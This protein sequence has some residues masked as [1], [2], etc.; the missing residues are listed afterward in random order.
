MGFIGFLGGGLVT[1]SLNTRG[2]VIPSQFPHNQLPSDPMAEINRAIRSI[3]LADYVPLLLAAFAVIFVL[4]IIFLYISCRFRFILFDSIITGQPVIGRGWARYSSQ[5]N[6]YFGFW[7]VFRLVSW[8]VMFFIVGLPLWRAYKSGTFSG[9]NSML[10]FLQIIGSIALG[11]L[12]AAIVFGIISTLVKDFVM[13]IM[14]LDDFSLGDAWS[15][16]WRVVSSEPGAWA[17]YL[18]LK[19]VCAIATGIGLAIV[20]VI[21]LLPALVIIGI[22]AGLFILLAALAYKLAGLAAG[23]I[24][25]C[26]AGLVVAAGVFCWICILIAPVTVFFASYA[27][28]FFGGRYPKL[29]AL[30]WP[31]S[32]PP[33]P[34]P[35]PPLGAQPAL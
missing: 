15:A 6:R 16:L 19:V 12:A 22:P 25:G 17:A 29:G 31:Q 18:A 13:P 5:A 27:F 26:V 9:D 34:Q 1:A 32:T 10:A 24:I 14:A 4:A 28:Y 11:A 35:L 7:L 3:H 20:G 21:T 23:I 33:A 30:L 2:P 8:T